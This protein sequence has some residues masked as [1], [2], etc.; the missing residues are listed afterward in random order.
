MQD[1]QAPTE[2]RAHGNGS[3]EDRDADEMM[4]QIMIGPGAR[5]V[6]IEMIDRN[7]FQPRKEF[8]PGELK[9]LSESLQKHGLLQPI[10]VRSVGERY[11][12][13][14]GERRLR[15]AMKAGWKEVPV[16]V[17]HVDD[18]QVAELALTENLQRK[19]L[20]P[21]EKAQAFQDY[22]EQYGGTHVELAN[23]LDIDRSTVTNLLRL[24]ELPEEI[25]QAVQKGKIAQGH[26]RA[27]LP[28]G[29]AT[30]QLEFCERIRQEGWSVRQT[31]AAVQ[32]VLQ[33]GA[34]ASS[35]GVIGRDGKAKGESRSEHLESLEQQIRSA[36]GTKVK[37]TA[38]PQGRGKLV[39]HFKNNDEFERIFQS[40][41]RQDLAARDAG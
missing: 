20:N 33:E 37:L 38:N 39:V 29:E 12:L 22:L 13:I 5:G 6:D 24:L 36:L 16:Q 14:A 41:C 31:E 30:E 26:A 7:P 21:I 23:R 2:T 18:R 17:I 34:P 25:R 28:L 15:A 35:W 9:A 11:Q 32:E 3:G 10:V 40:L 19:D 4:E 8:D 1:G 27:L